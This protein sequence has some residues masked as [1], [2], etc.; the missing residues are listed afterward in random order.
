MFR[1]VIYRHW[2]INDKGI[3]KSYIGQT[4]QQTVEQRWNNGKG[5][6]KDRDGKDADHNFARAITLDVL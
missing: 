1:G 3:E 6:L 5:Y 2:L 4:Y